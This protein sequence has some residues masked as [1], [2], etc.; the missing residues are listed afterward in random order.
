M[1]SFEWTFGGLGTSR[2]TS[3]NA[4]SGR[5]IRLAGRV[6]VVLPSDQLSLKIDVKVMNFSASHELGGQVQGPASSCNDLAVPGDC[7]VPSASTEHYDF[8]FMRCLTPVVSEVAITDGAVAKSNA[9]Q[10]G[11]GV[12]TFELTGSG[13]GTESCQN[14]VSFKYGDTSLQTDCIVSSTSATSVSCQLDVNDMM[15][16]QKTHMMRI[17]TKNHGL[18]VIGKYRQANYE[19]VSVVSSLTGSEGSFGGGTTIRIEGSGLK[20]LEDDAYTAVRLLTS[21]GQQANCVIQVHTYELIECKTSAVNSG[22][23]DEVTAD[24]YIFI[25]GDQT[26]PFWINEANP[27]HRST[28]TYKSAL[29]PTTGNVSS[30]TLDSASS[31]VT[32]EGTGFG[33]DASKVSVKL[34]SV[35]TTASSRAVV[36]ETDFDAMIERELDSHKRLRQPTTADFF[37]NHIHRFGS[38][39]WKHGGSKGSG[40]RMSTL[41]K[42]DLKPDFQRGARLIFDDD[43]EPHHLEEEDHDD[44]HLAHSFVQSRKRSTVLADMKARRQKEKVRMARL[45]LHL[46]D[47]AAETEV[48]GS[49]TSVSDTEVVV[50]FAD[51]P[52]GQYKIKVEVEGKGN[53]QSSSDTADMTV[54]G[55]VDSVS[56]AQGSTHGGQT[57]TIAGSGFTEGSTTVMMGDRECRVTSVTSMEITCITGANDGQTADSLPVKV[58][59]NGVSFP[60]SQTYSYSSTGQPEITSISPTSGVAGDTITIT[61]T[62]LTGA[63]AILGYGSLTLSSQSDTE[64]VGTVP[65]KKAG[66][67]ASAVVQVT[68]DFGDSNVQTFEYTTSVSSVSPTEASLG[69][70]AEITLSGTSLDSLATVTVCGRPCDKVSGDSTALTCVLSASNTTEAEEACSVFIK[71]HDFENELTDAITYKDSLTPKISSLDK[72]SGGTAGGTIVTITG[73]GF[74]PTDSSLK[75]DVTAHIDGSPCI[76]KDNNLIT[77]TTIVCETEPHKGSGKYPMKVFIPGKGLTK[78]ESEGSDLFYYVDRWSSP[79]TWGGEDPPRE[80]EFIVVSEGDTIILD[81]STPKLAFLLL[82]GNLIFDPE[83][84][85]L[86]LNTEFVL[87]MRGGS[88]QIGT[89]EEPYLNEATVMLHGHTRCTEIPIYGC[90]NIGVREGALELHGR[91]IVH[92]WTKLAQ[93]ASPGDTTITLLHDV[94]DWRVGDEIAIA[95]TEMRTVVGENEKR[96]ITAVS[97][98]TLTLDEPL[99][100]EHVS[101]SQTFDGRE[102]ET[103]GEVGLLTRNVKVLGNQNQQHL[104]EIE[105]CDREFDSDQH[106]TQSCFN[107]KFGE[108]LGSDEF[109]AT[110]LVHSKN[111]DKQ[112]AQARLEYVELF[113]VGQAFKVGRYPLHFHLMGNVSGSYSRGCAVH[114]S[115][116]RATTVHGVSELL[117]EHNVMY[118]IKGLSYFIEDGIEE[119]NIIQYNLAIFTRQSSS[120]LTPDITPAGFWIVNPNNIIRHNAAAGGTH[121]GFWFRI[122]K[123]PDGPSATSKYCTNRAPIGEFRNNTAHSFGW[124]G[125]WMFHMDGWFPSD[126][127][128]DKGYCN[129]ENEIPAKLYDFTAWRNDRGAEIVFGG[130]IQFVNFVVLDNLNTGLEFVEV[131]GEFSSPEKGCEEGPGTLDSLI[132]G[133]SE[134]SKDNGVCTK[135]GYLGAKVFT[136]YVC[137]TTFVNFENCAALGVCSQCVAPNAGFPGYVSGAKFINSPFKTN[138]KYKHS[139]AWIDVDGSLSG[140]A[141]STVLPNLNYLPSSGC[142]ANSDFDAGTSFL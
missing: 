59:S 31:S 83:Q 87:I 21:L 140:T 65:M 132:I 12:A 88:L 138:W 97:G 24:V 4:L 27:Q 44:G 115:F 90:K 51:V 47:R 13:F 89:E 63:T 53:A 49:V 56:P 84:T 81:Q 126:G 72:N 3:G 77:D 74:M 22:G 142:T 20:E 5:V 76:I 55:A 57:V 61:G 139:G 78:A 14:E 135:E 19:V 112:E 32:L 15:L 62:S 86:T 108:E 17:R 127:T 118:N 101:I 6:N 124:Y 43:H 48:S 123:H 134:L 125:I 136:T 104:T 79:Y 122:M 121:F 38:V 93:T 69:G 117:L 128:K 46:E 80:D 75:S 107:G 18:G 98:N 23:Q 52:A 10:E 92:P 137:N 71:Q 25:G 82:Y 34:V 129:W 133:S 113:W 85:G 33:T 50:T 35:A 42:A 36:G 119:D 94:S 131:K 8:S 99:E 103:R 54:T 70:G 130:K 114:N 26:E 109:G 29:T 58:V 45:A 120:L 73:T 111:P 30:S 39:V 1:G 95:S 9:T 91:P 11:T 40:E 105:A 110:I 96:T 67:L 2:Y 7:A 116:N 68:T 41:T 64:L 66:A 100:Y 106:A 28:F 102:V 60:E 141:E 37:K 16:P